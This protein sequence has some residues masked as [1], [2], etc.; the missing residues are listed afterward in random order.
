MYSLTNKLT[1]TLGAV[2]FA[3]FL[4]GTPGWAGETTLAHN[5]RGARNTIVE[6]AENHPI[7]HDASAP[8]LA[9]NEDAAR[10]VFVD[11]GNSIPARARIAMDGATLS[12][13]EL[14][15]QRAIADASASEKV[16]LR[17]VSASLAAASAAAR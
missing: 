7:F 14:A 5:E 15:A 4:T 1:T 2:L 17:S 12:R 3:S 9:H 11:A 10:R 8:T 16:A 6:T 13:N